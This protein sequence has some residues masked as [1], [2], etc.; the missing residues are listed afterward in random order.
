MR[1]LAL[2]FLAGCAAAPRLSREAA[3]EMEQ[4]PDPTRADW[5]LHIDTRDRGI[6]AYTISIRY[7]PE[8]AVIEEILPCSP[9]YF[10][11][12]PEVDP[13][14]FK[15]GLTRVTSLDVF[16]SRPR[17]GQWHLFTVVF[18]RTGPGTLSAKAQIEKLYDDENKPFTGRLMDSDFVS[19]FP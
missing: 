13:A 2:L 3:P 4:R 9:K 14:S 7:N 16:G 12:T 19:T 18:R 5:R 1:A 15:S 6:G 8:V 17:A 10:K 11:G